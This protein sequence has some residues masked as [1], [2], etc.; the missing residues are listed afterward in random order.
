MR[1]ILFFFSLYLFFQNIIIGQ[2]ANVHFEITDLSTQ[3]LTPAKIVLLQNGD[4]FEHGLESTTDLACRRHTIYTRTGKGSFEIPVGD[5]EIWVGKGME[6]GV[7]VNLHSFKSG[8]INSLKVA[9]EKELDTEGYIGGDMHLH[10]YT[11][12][13]HGDATVEERLISCVAEGLEWAVSTDHNTVL[14]YAPYM[15]KLGL[16]GLMHTSVGN[17]VSTPIGHFN[18]YP[19][20]AGSKPVNS[21]IT[22]GK[23]LFETIRKEAPENV[24]VQINHPRWIDSDF[25]NT[26]GLDP[27]FGTS[28]HPE[29][30]W[31]FDAFE[32]LNENF[33][34]GWRAAPDNKFSV[35]ND[36]F[37]LLNQGEK[38][39]GLGNSDSHS[40]I[41]QIAGIPRNYVK[42]STD[43]PTKINEKEL[44]QSLKNQRVSVASGIFV[45]LMANG[46]NGPGSTVKLDDEGLMFRLRVQAASWISCNKAELVENGQVIQSFDIPKSK[47]TVR[48]DKKISIKPKKDSWYILIAYGD[49]PMTPMVQFKEK[50]A[51]PKGF[52][53]PIWVDADGDG[54]LTSVFEYSKKRLDGLKGDPDGLLAAMQAEPDIVYPLFYHL[55]E[56]KMAVAPKVASAFLKTADTRSKMMLYRELS[57]MGDKKATGVL[58]QEKRAQLSPL[59]EVVLN[60][61][62]AF[63]IAE[64]RVEKFKKKEH[65]LLDEELNWLEDEFR[66]LFSGATKKSFQISRANPQNNLVTLDWRTVDAPAE[67]ILPLGDLLKEKQGANYYIY[68]PLYARTDTTIT[69]YINTNTSLKVLREGRVLNAIFA[70]EGYPIGA[71]LVRIKIKKGKNDLIF[72]MPAEENARIALQ[73]INLDKLLDPNLE[74]TQTVAHLAVDKKVRY[75]VEYAPKYHGHGVALTD[76]YRGTTNFRDQLWQGWNGE[77]AEFIVDLGEANQIKEVSL[78]IL[79]NQDSWIFAPKSVECTFSTNGR[80]FYTRQKIDLN[81]LEK[82]AESY[83]EDVNVSKLPVTARYVK[84]VAHKIPELPQ[85][86]AGKGGD[87]W[88]VLDEII[89]R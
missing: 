51:Y 5:Y 42:S 27:F 3:K 68:H 48:L 47:S 70:N 24:V 39:T 63:P 82:R 37:N 83:I 7:Y 26:K 29:W 4:P 9:L 33:G 60:Y 11:F 80:D 17:E 52:T 23:T 57:K 18:T 31:G 72:Q 58:L 73:E 45:N 49:E 32:I 64:N 65:T 38:I 87:A 44:I 71:K 25:F 46:E 16:Q 77:N 88:I 85:W 56:Q 43:D 78:G 40:V 35:K 15:E 19:L 12:S 13:G 36:W 10:T 66:F 79:V 53:N 6:Y 67:G 69:F 81:P 74:H 1:K 30:D 76:G 55:F 61:Y 20:V 14:N 62:L 34:L 89:I 84:I 8:Q 2:K 28:K 86:H 22:V 54:K 50:P 75:L 21:K 41:A 59:E